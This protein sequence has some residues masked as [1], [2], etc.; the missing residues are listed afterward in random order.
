MA[1]LIIA[2]LCFIWRHRR[3]AKAKRDV[4]EVLRSEKDPYAGKPEL[5]GEARDP[6]K[7]Q[8]PEW[9]LDAQ[10]RAMPVELPAQSNVLTEMPGQ[11]SPDTPQAELPGDFGVAAKGSTGDDDAG[12]D[13]FE[14]KDGNGRHSPAQDT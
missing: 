4:S 5:D 7:S 9:E 12:T 6:Y 11:K 14:I 13:K 2:A 3:K 8:S 1:I 10:G